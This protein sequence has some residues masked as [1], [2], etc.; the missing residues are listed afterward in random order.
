MFCYIQYEEVDVC[1]IIYSMKKLMFDVL[2]YTV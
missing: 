1:S 2:L